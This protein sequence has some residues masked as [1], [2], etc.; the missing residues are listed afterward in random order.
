MGSAQ[1]AW[2]ESSKNVVFD[3]FVEKLVVDAF[4]E[5]L[6][7]GLGRP[8]LANDDFFLKRAARN[9]CFT[10]RFWLHALKKKSSLAKTVAARVKN[11]LVVPHALKINS[12]RP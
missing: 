4:V 5:K 1:P 11:K 10:T 7:V 8:V 6:V 2:P 12:R 9:A 3:A